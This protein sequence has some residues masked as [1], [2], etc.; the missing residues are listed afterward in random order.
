MQDCLFEEWLRNIDEQP[1]AQVSDNM[2]RI[3]R[4]EKAGWN[5]D[6]EYD[7]DHGASLLKSLVVQNPALAH[8]N[9]PIDSHGLSS[10]KTAIRKYISFRDYCRF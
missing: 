4:L 3:R 5:L 8:C 7:N 1:Q 2:S 6:K 10:L 9:L